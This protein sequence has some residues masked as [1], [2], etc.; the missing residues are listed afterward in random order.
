[1]VPPSLRGV[2]P[3]EVLMAA[4]AASPG[5]FGARE[6]LGD[7]NVLVVGD[8]S[9]DLGRLTADLAERGFRRLLCEGGPTLLT[10]LLAA[11]LVDELCTTQVP[12][13]FGG[14][15][16]RI[17]AGAAVDHPLDLRLLLEEDGTLLARWHVRH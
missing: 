8:D 2:Q 9:V 16:G 10:A 4:C 5:L 11:G 15:Q 1:M 6:A 7:E 14:A 3:G 13:V 12:H 17:T